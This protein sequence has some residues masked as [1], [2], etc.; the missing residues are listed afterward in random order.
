MSN[1]WNQ[2]FIIFVLMSCSLT[3]FAQ[4][5]SQDTPKGNSPYS[6]LGL[7]DLINQNFAAASSYGGLGATFYN[8][9]RLNS[10]NPAANGYLKATAFEVGVFGEYS[11]LQGTN[12]EEGF[13]NG[14]LNYLSLA[15]PLR[16][17]I[18]EVLD[19]KNTDLSLSMN[20]SLIPYSVVGYDI[21]GQGIVGAN[22]DTTQNQFQGRGGTYK[23]LWGN[24]MK[25]KDISFGLNL[26]YIFGKITNDRSVS[27]LDSEGN[28]EAN[29]YRDQLVDEFSLTGLIWNAGMMY[30]HQFK[31]MKDGKLVPNGK[32]IIIGA[33]GNSKNS[34][35]TNT[36]QLFF[37]NNPNYNVPADTIRNVTD[38]KGEAVL[39]AE[40][41]IGVMF[42]K[43]FKY[44]L[45]ID[46][47]AAKWSQYKNDAKPEALL[48]TWRIAV[49]GEYTPDYLSYNSQWKRIRYR[50]GFFYQ[51]DPRVVNEQLSS[52][53]LTLGMGIPVVL[54]RGQVSFI[55]LAIELGK[56]GS[57]SSIQ[58][59]YVKLTAGFTLNDNTWFFKRKFN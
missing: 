24:T 35:N 11:K 3:V 49:G 30:R 41:G 36:S 40:F 47:S 37:R 26:G 57:A 53:G 19:R 50:G 58:E 16:N 20:F 5:D 38:L 21:E 43:E 13:W 17:V 22:L 42:E 2:F 45:G 51:N 4:P 28:N 18:S 54:A 55:D 25:Y 32:N 48:D 27:F 33:Y 10:I 59:T 39:P 1:N 52:Y 46:Y 15:F 56:F 7:G 8:S 9:Y 44:R 23:I 12:L 29:Y 31:S 6:R 14:N 34:V